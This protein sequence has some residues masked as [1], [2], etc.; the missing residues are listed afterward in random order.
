MSE[1]M[2]LNIRIQWNAGTACVSECVLSKNASVSG[3]ACRPF[4]V[5]K[6]VS[7]E[8]SVPPKKTKSTKDI[9]PSSTFGT[10]NATAKRGAQSCKNL[11]LRTPFSF[12]GR[13]GK[14]NQRKADSQAGSRICPPPP[15]KTRSIHKNPPN[16]RTALIFVNSPCFCG[17][18]TPNSRKHPNIMNR[19]ANRP[20]FG[21][22]CRRDPRVLIKL[23]APCSPGSVRQERG[24][25]TQT[26]ES[27]Y[28]PVGWRSS[29]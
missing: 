9:G 10:Q 11:P 27:G 14:P 26:F 25:H 15:G 16:S 23:E 29:V 1:K 18:S 3:F 19:L 28:P 13:P 24:A 2:P 20:F 21:L 5:A 22:V 7:A 17:K 8:S 12:R 4:Q 6:W